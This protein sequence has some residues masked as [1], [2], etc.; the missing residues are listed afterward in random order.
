MNARIYIEGGGDSK[1]LHTRCREG[2]RRLLEKM[3]LA[4][5]MPRLVACGGRSAT[6]DDFKI[7]HDNAASEAYVGM[8]VDSEDPIAEIE[9]T[10]AHLKQR[11]DWDRP[12][13]A[14]DEQVLLMVTCME[15]WIVTDRET[16]RSHYGSKLQDSALPALNDVETRDRD[17][18][19][20]ALLRATRDCTNAYAK[21]RRSFEVVS[22]LEPSALRAHLPSFVRCERILGEKL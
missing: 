20:N 16:L 15:S 18:V 13:G 8:L 3:G 4:R 7:A 5:R 14:E 1:E 6:F 10:W 22:A 9:A 2:F 17:S 12:D 11:D 21:G 19:Q